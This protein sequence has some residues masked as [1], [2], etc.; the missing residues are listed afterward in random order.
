VAAQTDA[1]KASVKSNGRSARTASDE[2]AQNMVWSWRVSF[3]VVVLT[4]RSAAAL[5]PQSPCPQ[6]FYYYEDSRT[7]QILGA[8]NVPP[9]RDALNV[10]V[11]AHFI[12]QTLLQTVRK[13]LA[14]DFL[15]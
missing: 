10:S 14:A 9:P 13:E 6:L 5:M 8:L 1:P 2:S 4:Q 7:S 15:P 11:Q 3:L 12:V